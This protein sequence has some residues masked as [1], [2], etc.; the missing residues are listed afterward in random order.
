MKNKIV[1]IISL[2]GITILFNGCWLT[3]GADKGYCE[4]CGYEADGFCGNPID[5]YKN[6]YL[7]SNLYDKNIHN[8]DLEEYVEQKEEEKEKNKPKKREPF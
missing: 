3:I 5:I 7:I 2:A 4:D 6:R 1:K 8:K